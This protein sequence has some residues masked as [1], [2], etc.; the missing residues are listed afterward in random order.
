MR[1]R[2]WSYMRAPFMP[3]MR[4][5]FL[6]LGD[7]RTLPRRTDRDPVLGAG[8]PQVGARGLGCR[9]RRGRERRMCG[10]VAP[11]PGPIART[12]RPDLSPDLSPGAAGEG[13]AGGVRAAGAVHSAAGVRG[14]GGEVQPPHRR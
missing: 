1:A 11:T 8:S 9:S 7:G 4:I 6:G 14:G 3:R 10:V 13:G 2:T 12:Y 5:P